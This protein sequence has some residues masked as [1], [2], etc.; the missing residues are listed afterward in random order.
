M[1]AVKDGVIEREQR[2]EIKYNEEKRRYEPRNQ[3]QRGHESSPTGG[4]ATDD[5]VE[6]H[7][8]KG[9]IR[10]SSVGEWVSEQ[11]ER[12][13]QLLP[14]LAGSATGRGRE[15]VFHWQARGREGLFCEGL[16]QAWACA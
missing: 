10:H 3:A 11:V 13:S 1:G 4:V 2:G 7:V 14:A 12:G 15:R 16:L 9:R 5:T 8:Y 6:R